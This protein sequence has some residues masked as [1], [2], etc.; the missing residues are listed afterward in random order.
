MPSRITPAT[1]RRAHAEQP[2]PPLQFRHT[3]PYGAVLHD[4]GPG[5]DRGVQFV[6]YSRSATAM[7]VLL[8]DRVDDPEPV[9]VIALDP[10]KDR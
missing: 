6:V 8:Y 7:R 10:A 5:R 2:L 1:A 3:L 9:E 4:G